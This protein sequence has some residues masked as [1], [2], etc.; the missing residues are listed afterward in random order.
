MPSLGL[1]FPNQKTPVPCLLLANMPLSTMCLFTCGRSGG[2]S[3]PQSETA[4]SAEATPV[5]GQPT[6]E[7]LGTLQWPQGSRQGTGRK[8]AQSPPSSDKLHAPSKYP[9]DEKKR[10]RE[11]ETK[12]QITFIGKASPALC[13]IAQILPHGFPTPFK[14]RALGECQAPC[15]LLCYYLFRVLF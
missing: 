14:G 3:L 11:K 13:A 8:T 15:W 7:D 10:E 9:P 2:R 6:N 12:N 4:P 1:S 5:G